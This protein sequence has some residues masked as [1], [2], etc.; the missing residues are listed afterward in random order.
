MS[1]YGEFRKDT[2]ADMYEAIPEE[3]ELFDRAIAYVEKNY[4]EKI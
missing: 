4:G 1:Y 2:V 3:L